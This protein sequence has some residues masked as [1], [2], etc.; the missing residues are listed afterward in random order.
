MNTR[1]NATAEGI[2]AE[3]TRKLQS[4]STTEQMNSAIRQTADSINTEVS[5]KVNGDEIIS[6]IMKVLILR[7]K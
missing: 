2:S 5:K 4:Y 7:K 3:V 1:I 6:K